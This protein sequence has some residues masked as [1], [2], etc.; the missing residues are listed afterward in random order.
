MSLRFHHSVARF[1]VIMALA[2]LL[3]LGASN[4]T[5]PSAH[6]AAA[7]ASATTSAK[8]PAL[9]LGW[10]GPSS[11]SVNSELHYVVQYRSGTQCCGVGFMAYWGDG[12]NDLITCYAWCT[13]GSLDFYT[14]YNHTG[15]FGNHCMASGADSNWIYVHIA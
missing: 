3:A 11:G 2:L 12:S 14:F 9:I 10:N 1:A 15:W 4:F 5:V 8:I 6:A 13:E 7:T